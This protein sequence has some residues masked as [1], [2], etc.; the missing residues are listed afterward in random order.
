V[1]GHLEVVSAAPGTAEV[2]PCAH[3]GKPPVPAKKLPHLSQCTPVVQD[4]GDLRLKLA[5]GKAPGGKAPSPQQAKREK[6]LAEALKNLPAETRPLVVIT[7]DQARADWT[8]WVKGDKVQL[9]EGDG[10]S[11]IDPREEA[12][13]AKKA[14][15]GKPLRRRVFG[16]YDADNP[17]E[18]AQQL[19]RDLRKIFTWQNVW[20]VAAAAQQPPNAEDAAPAGKPDVVGR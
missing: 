19:G 3:A 14:K 8:L 1:L 5:I 2:K 15:S 7:E 17:R 11:S 6:D 16:D 20:R 12:L 13:L 18:G 10:R 4:L 9:R